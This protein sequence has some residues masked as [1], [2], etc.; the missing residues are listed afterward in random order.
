[1]RRCS[2]IVLTVSVESCL[3]HAEPA[4]WAGNT[5][6]ASGSVQQ[7]VVDRVV[8]LAAELVGRGACCREEVGASDVADEQCVSGQHT[9]RFSTRAF[10][11]DDADRLRCVAGGLADL[12]ADGA[13]LEALA[14]GHR[15]IGKPT[16]PAA[17]AP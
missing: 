11:D 13:E 5:L 2:P 16:R 12:E 1:M 9:E 8:E 10:P 7:L 17:A 6:V 15:R 14:V 3:P 4:P